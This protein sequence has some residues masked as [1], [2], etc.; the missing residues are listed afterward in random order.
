MTNSEVASES[1][2]RLCLCLTGRVMVPILQTVF[3]ALLRSP[4][5][6]QRYAALQTMCIMGEGC[7]E[8]I[9]NDLEAF[10]RMMVPFISDEH[11][12]VRYA[13][14]N[15]LGQMCKL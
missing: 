3:P 12:R 4:N 5:W 8:E 11:P 10:V 7:N 2:D 15:T 1:L 13:S 6:K 9:A 14:L